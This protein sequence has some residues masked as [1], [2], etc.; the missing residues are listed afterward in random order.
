MLPRA[1]WLPRPP[2]R[3]IAT[4]Q[5]LYPGSAVIHPEPSLTRH[6][7]RVHIVRPPGLPLTCG[8]RM[9]RAPSG[10]PLAPH[11]REQD[12]RT[13]ARAGTGSEHKPGTTPP[14]QPT[15]ALQSA[16]SLA[17]VRPRV[18]R[19]ARNTPSGGRQQ[20]APL[21]P[22]PGH[23]DDLI[24]QLRR[25]RPRQHLHRDPVRQPA[26]RREPLRTIMSHGTVTISHQTLKQGHWPVRAAPRYPY[27]SS[28]NPRVK[29]AMR[30][31]ELT[32]EYD[33]RH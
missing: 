15:S 5:V 19:P 20:P 28:S 16:S 10:F 3:R 11:P 25:E 33:I 13:H 31:A 30:I 14:T 7:S 22:C 23:L 26:V 32:T 8:P 27:R 2:A 6:Q 17:H 18:A 12:P 1:G 21:L 4:A 9:T 29:G 24:D